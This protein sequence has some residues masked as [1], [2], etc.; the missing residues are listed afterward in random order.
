M[1]LTLGCRWE[2]GGL[3]RANVDGLRSEKPESEDSEEEER[4]V[5]KTGKSRCLLL[6]TSG[7]DACASELSVGSG[8]LPLLPWEC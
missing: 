7:G 2:Y 5:T 6:D 4:E 3:S 8:L 1:L